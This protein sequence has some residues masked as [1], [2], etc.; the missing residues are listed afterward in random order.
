MSLILDALRKSEAERR[1]GQAPDLHAELP[2]A[3]QSA[4]AG[5]PAW[6]WLLALAAT[7]IVVALV[8]T[9]LA[10]D[11]RAPAPEAA[12]AVLDSP[13]ERLPDRIAG[14]EPADIAEVR[15]GADP[16]SDRGSVS[17]P[18]TAAAPPPAVATIAPAEPVTA[19]SPRRE[20]IATPPRDGGDGRTLATQEPAAPPSAVKRPVAAPTPGPPSASPSAPLAPPAPPVAVATPPIP[21]APS[22]PEDADKRAPL[23]LAALAAAERRALPPLKISMHMWAPTSA[24][25]F[26]IIDGARVNEGDRLG[27]AVVDEI[28]RD[29]VVLAWQGR[30]VQIPI[31]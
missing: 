18:E 16:G 27:D 6:P 15:T 23:Q 4:R 10:R 30:R 9:W 13:P 17:A 29:G 26:A 28:T 24:G 11:P 5:R 12:D 8:M 2:P 3:V 20:P 25:R 7:A 14:S 1:R 21:A 19:P 22:T 31:H